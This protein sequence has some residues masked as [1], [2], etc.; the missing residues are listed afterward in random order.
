MG[1]LP[2]YLRS[3]LEDHPVDE[4]PKVDRRSEDQE[5]VVSLL[6][7][8]SFGTDPAVELEHTYHD[9]VASGDLVAV[10]PRALARAH[11]SSFHL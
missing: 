7:T 1:A 6:D 10:S 11:S 9:R 3:W 5:I 8:L 4:A 2:L